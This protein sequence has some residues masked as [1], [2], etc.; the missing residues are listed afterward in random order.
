MRPLDTPPEPADAGGGRAREREGF[1][2]RKGE[3][4]FHMP[5]VC[6]YFTL[7]SVNGRTPHPLCVAETHAGGASGLW[8]LTWSVRRVPPDPLQRRIFIT[9]KV[10]FPH[11]LSRPLGGRACPAGEARPSARVGGR[12]RRAVGA[13]VGTFSS[14]ENIGSE[15]WSFRS[16]H[17]RLRLRR[18]HSS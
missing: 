15:N 7:L 11:L 14:A 17:C 2:P 4:W 13:G 18:L 6:H 1:Y 3:A 9:L 5:A 16:C 10:T 12:G 8:S